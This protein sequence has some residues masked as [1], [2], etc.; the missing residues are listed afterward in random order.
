M[1]VLLK[2][3]SANIYSGLLHGVLNDASYRVP[4]QQ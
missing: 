1:Y 4:L 3:D 2:L